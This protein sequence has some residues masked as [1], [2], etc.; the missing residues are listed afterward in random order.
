MAHWS[1]TDARDK[2][3]H[4]GYSLLVYILGV[5]LASLH[6]RDIGLALLA[7][8]STPRV[9]EWVR[10]VAHGLTDPPDAAAFGE[11]VGTLARRHNVAVIL[12]QRLAGLPWNLYF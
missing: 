2:A 1:I 10:P 4:L 6:Y 11:F 7:A 12:S 9:V 5:D 3:H 8:G